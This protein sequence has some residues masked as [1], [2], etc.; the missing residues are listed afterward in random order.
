MVGIFSKNRKEW[1]IVDI[2]CVLFRMT[3]VPLYD[4][5]GEEGISHILKSSNI[6]S[7]F[8]NDS[9]LKVLMKSKFY[10]DLKNIIS[11]DKFTEEQQAH[12][13]EKGIN[14]RQYK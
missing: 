14:L 5:L 8:V 7:L 3:T 2:A 10:G 4:T 6:T 1:T 11:F 13:K 9:S 12:F